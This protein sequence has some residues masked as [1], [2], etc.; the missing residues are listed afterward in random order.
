MFEFASR[1]LE[2]SFAYWVKCTYKKFRSVL[3]LLQKSSWYDKGG[4]KLHLFQQHDFPFN[5]YKSKANSYSKEPG[6]LM[7]Q[8]SGKHILIILK[9]CQ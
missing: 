6:L 5:V 2:S 8:D 3:G 4:H 1:C 9:I 7:D